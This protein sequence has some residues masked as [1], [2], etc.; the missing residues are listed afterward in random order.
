MAKTFGAFDLVGGEM[1]AEL[2]LLYDENILAS[3]DLSSLVPVRG[4]DNKIMEKELSFRHWMPSITWD[5][6]DWIGPKRFKSI[7]ELEY[8][9]ARQST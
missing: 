3:L 1:E 6:C 9:D 7:L 5:T 4:Q 2:Y 8:Q